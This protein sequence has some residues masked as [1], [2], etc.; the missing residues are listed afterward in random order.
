MTVHILSDSGA[1]GD[2]SGGPDD[3]DDK[4]PHVFVHYCYWHERL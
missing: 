2:G 3:C 1:D 4:R